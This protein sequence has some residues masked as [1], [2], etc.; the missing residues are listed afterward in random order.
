MI[1]MF[2][3]RVACVKKIG[4]FGTWGRRDTEQ[5]WM[6]IF[7]CKNDVQ[8]LCTNHGSSNLDLPVWDAEWMEKKGAEKQHRD[9]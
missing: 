9:P 3:V 7:T 2:Q 1:S 8:V 5:P 4:D 6:A